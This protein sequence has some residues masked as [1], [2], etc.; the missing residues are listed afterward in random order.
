MKEIFYRLKRLL[1]STRYIILI[2]SDITSNKIHFPLSFHFFNLLSEI[3]IWQET[4]IWDKTVEFNDKKHRVQKYL[5]QLFSFYYK[6]NWTHEYILIF[7]KSTELARSD[8]NKDEYFNKTEFLY[9]YSRSIWHITPIPPDLQDIHPA[10]FPFEIPHH[11]IKYFSNR[12][13]VIFDCFAGF[14]TTLIEAL[15]LGRIAVGN[16]KEKKYCNLMEKNIKIFLKNP[17][18]FNNEVKLYRMKMIIKSLKERHL[19]KLDIIEFLVKKQYS[20]ELIHE[21]I[22]RF[23]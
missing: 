18:Y 11:I 9:N 5:Y 1:K 2:I 10:R 7:S 23:Y 6:P 8:Y 19:Q 4:I 21:A 17:N 14:G 13:D 12:K 15:R 16:D 20:N 3:Y 22:K